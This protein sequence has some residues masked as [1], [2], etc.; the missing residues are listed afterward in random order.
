MASIF[1]VDAHAAGE[2]CRVVVGG[3][4][5]LSGMSVAERRADFRARY[6][7]MRTAL[8]L[9]P[10]GHSGMFGA[11][12]L[13]AERETSDF[14]LVFFD[15]VGYLDG[16]GHGTL[17]AVA[18]RERLAGPPSLPLG[19]DNPDGS[20]TRVVELTVARDRCTATLQMPPA[21][22][23][24]PHLSLPG[25]PADA[26][27]L[28][29]CG[30]LYLAVRADALDISDLHSLPPS[31]LRAAAAKVREVAG[32]RLE[33]SADLPAGPAREWL[34]VALY[35]RTDGTGAAEEVDPVA[36]SLA[37]AVLFSQTQLDRSPCGTG[38]CSVFA[39]LLARGELAASDDLRTVGP[40]GGA[41]HLRAPER[42]S[43]AGGRFLLTGTA[44]ITGVHQWIVGEEDPI[45]SGF[46]F[47]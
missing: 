26:G 11:L 38:S 39:L 42:P 20:V 9:E 37:T 34:E 17:C 1:T 3:L 4:P 5:T 28:A 22:V 24:D 29:R 36:C 18:V 2:P 23:L 10:R 27:G 6:D 41:F 25:L 21:E 19:I 46:R 35:Q 40:L 15:P 47:E 8:M 30:N 12:L 43:A 31:E 14:G 7:W 16:C 44:D 32:S 45:R 33:G 13:P